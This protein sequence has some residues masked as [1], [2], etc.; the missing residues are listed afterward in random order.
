[1]ATNGTRD[2]GRFSDL[3]EMLEYSAMRFG[4]CVAIHEKR[5]GFYQHISYGRLFEEI[6]A[7]G[8]ALE[9]LL[10]KAPRVLLW[11]KN[12]YMQTLSFLSLLCG[13]G[14][15]VLAS[16]S[17]GDED[18][19]ALVE[20]CGACAILCDRDLKVRAEALSLPVYCYEDLC[21]LMEK[22]RAMI[23]SG[24]YTVFE[25]PIDLKAVAAVFSSHGRDIALSHEAMVE[26]VRL[27]AES[28]AIGTRDTFLSVLPLAQAHE[29]LLGLLFPLSQGAS[30]AFAEGTRRLLSNMREIHPTCMVTVPYLAAKLYDKFWSLA[31]GREREIRRVIA[32][33]DPVRPLSARQALKTRL[34]SSARAPFGGALRCLFLVGTPLEAMLSKGLRQI[35]IFT[36]CTYGLAECGRLAAVTSPA[37]YLDGT[38]G[39]VLKGVLDI[40]HPQ[41]DGSGDILVNGTP[42]G[43]RGRV[44]EN[45]FLHVVG[46]T[47]NAIVLGNGTV[48]SPEEIQRLL[49]QSPLIKEAAAVGVP[50]AEGVEL[51]VMLVPNIEDL[52]HILGKDYTNEDLERATSEWLGNVNEGVAEDARI[53]LFALSAE[54]LPRDASGALVRE[55]IIQMLIAAQGEEDFSQ[56]E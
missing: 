41:Q 3:R 55:E 56:E 40:G 12:S 11:G 13:A 27:L 26:T 39:K 53:A 15:P 5:S 50:T 18:F 47:V 52:E 45:G 30:V 9:P 23:A 44:D 21:P 8:T 10:P 48:I 38:A 31:E 32:T 28:N 16:V 24:E 51:A 35:G 20:R 2:V 22:G 46:K 1:M 43:E 33:T 17:I 34:L 49:R 25:A 36:A 42:T 54:P 29:A 37:A 14:L 7:L 19:A 6:E 4:T